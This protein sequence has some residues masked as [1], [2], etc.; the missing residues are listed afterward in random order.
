MLFKWILPGKCM[1]SKK[2]AQIL[3]KTSL[4]EP[5][6]L[7][8]PQKVISR[9]LFTKYC[10]LILVKWFPTPVVTSATRDKHLGHCLHCLS[11]AGPS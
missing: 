6:F 11:P 7:S 8:H 4:F 10:P 1:P 9:W 5:P 2:Y 3:L